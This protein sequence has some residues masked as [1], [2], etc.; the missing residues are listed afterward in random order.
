MK[1][2]LYVFFLLI[3]TYHKYVFDFSE[4]NIK[5]IITTNDSLCGM[6]NKKKIFLFKN[7]KY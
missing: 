2:L 7:E 6:Y 4:K 5:K 3:K 1:I